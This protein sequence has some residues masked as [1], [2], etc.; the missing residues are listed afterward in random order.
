[1]GCAC[2]QDRAVSEV[3]GQESGFDLSMWFSRWSS[4]P[5]SSLCYQTW[6]CDS[7]GSDTRTPSI[8]LPPVTAKGRLLLPDT[9]C[10]TPSPARLL[11]ETL[12]GPVPP[13]WCCLPCSSEWCPSPLLSHCAPASGPSCIFN[14]HNIQCRCYVKQPAWLKQAELS[15]NTVKSK[16]LLN[17]QEADWNH[18]I[19]MPYPVAFMLVD[20]DF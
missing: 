20:V 12:L 8:P 15:R 2:A 18:K 5:A 14:Y 16:G 9:S 13:T 17:Y 3:H 19:P 10:L 6:S 1:M 11:A 7:R 4:D